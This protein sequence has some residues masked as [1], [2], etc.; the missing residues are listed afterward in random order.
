M[1]DI[2]PQ[3]IAFDAM[4]VQADHHAVV[5]FYAAALHGERQP[6][7]STRSPRLIAA[8]ISSRMAFTMFSISR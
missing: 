2:R 1:A 6:G 3:L 5:Q 8:V 4:N 7:N